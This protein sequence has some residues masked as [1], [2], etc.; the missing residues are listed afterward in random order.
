M[1][2]GEVTQRQRQLITE[3][4]QMLESMQAL[5]RVTCEEIERARTCM[6]CRWDAS[7]CPMR[8]VSGSCDVRDRLHG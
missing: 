8:R 4:E 7:R 5:L 2:T 3:A 1:A 6:Q